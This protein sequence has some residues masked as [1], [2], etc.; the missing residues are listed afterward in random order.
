M[1]TFWIGQDVPEKWDNWDIDY[2]QKLK[3][4]VDQRMISRNVVS[5]GPLQ[6]RIRSKYKIG[7]KSEMVQDMVF[8]AENAR[9]DFETV[10]DWN[11]KHKL[12]KAGFDIDILSSYAR[13]EMQYGYVDRPMHEN[14]L[15]D[16][17]QFEVC[18]HKWTDISEAD[19]GVAILNDCKYGISA[20]SSDLRLSLLKAGRHPDGRGDKGRHEFTYSILPHDG[21]F[22]VKSVVRPAYELNMPV[23]SCL[24][25]ANTKALDSFVSVDKDNVIVETVKV[26][27]DK[28][29]IVLR[30]Y[31]AAKS[32]TKARLKFS[33]TLKR[34][35]E[36]NMLEENRVEIASK[37]DALSLSF[38]PFEIKT[39]YCEIKK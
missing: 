27:E 15:Q 1:N 6:L 25:A 24:A 22:S 7:N 5:D 38:R 29:G 3:M 13:H 19:F 8:H 33:T 23:K 31:E 26:S 4:A 21:A 37:K 14:E 36:T 17:A 39:I 10:I 16:R 11:E 9:V 18:N 30:L 20:D 34:V 2:D 28:K 32:R 35:Y 12:L